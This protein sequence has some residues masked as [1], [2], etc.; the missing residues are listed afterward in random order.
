MGL[1]CLTKGCN[2]YGQIGLGTSEPYSGI[3][4]PVAKL[5]G[6]FVKKISCGPDQSAA[7][8]SED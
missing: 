1:L 5:M 7:I 4:K 6:E 3:P 8:T 2:K